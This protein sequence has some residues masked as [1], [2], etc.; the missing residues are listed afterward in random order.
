MLQRLESVDRWTR[1][2]LE[3]ILQ[4]RMC[5]IASRDK[6]ISWLQ[7]SLEEARTRSTQAKDDFYR[8]R[9]EKDQ[10]ERA[11]ASLRAEVT[12]QKAEIVT[13]REAVV[14]K[15][16]SLKTATDRCKELEGMVAFRDGVDARRAVVCQQELE[17]LEKNR[18]TAE[19]SR[20]Q[21][22]IAWDQHEQVSKELAAVRGELEKV[23]AAL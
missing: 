7:G 21:A 10:L 15:M 6:Q 1:G 2:E 9:E 8:A 12:S 22:Q 13:L 18:E 17:E 23:Q 3:H 19:A 16:R 5:G 11:V 14:A 4:E 20:S